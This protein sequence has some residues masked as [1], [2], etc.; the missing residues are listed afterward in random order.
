M[1]NRDVAP[2]LSLSLSLSFSP[3]AT[4][5]KGWLLVTG[6]CR[7]VSARASPHSTK[8][9]SSPLSSLLHSSTF[10]SHFY[11]FVSSTFPRFPFSTTSENE[12]RFPVAIVRDPSFFF[13]VDFE[14]RVGLSPTE[15][16]L[17]VTGALSR[18]KIELH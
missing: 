16:P 5:G 2:L 13:P 1:E 15:W 17:T 4:G 10:P 7:F 12:R 11:L 6:R 14:K 9:R 8:L 18:N 3:L